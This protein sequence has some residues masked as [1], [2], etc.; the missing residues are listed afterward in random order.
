MLTAGHAVVSSVAEQG[1]VISS[2][3]TGEAIGSLFC[4]TNIDGNPTADA[5][6]IWVDPAKVAARI[7]G[8]TAPTLVNTRPAE[9]DVVRIMPAQVGGVPRQA[10]I[11]AI[12]QAVDL[13]V[14]GPGWPEAPTIT[15]QGQ[16]FTDDLI[17]DAGDSG[18][19]VLDWQ[20]QAVG[21]VVAGSLETGT[22]ITPITAIFA[23][24]A[25]G[26]MRMALLKDI[27][28]APLLP[29]LAPSDSMVGGAADGVADR[30][31]TIAAVNGMAMA[32]ALGAQAQDAKNALTDVVFEPASPEE[33][34][35]LLT[36]SAIATMRNFGVPAS[37]TIA[38][39]ALESGWGKSKL[40][41]NGRNLF[42]VKADVSWTGDKITMYTREFANGAPV[43]VEAV[44]RKYPGLQACLDDHAKFFRDNPRYSGCFQFKDG[45]GFTNAVAGAGY[46]TD[47]NYAKKL[48]AT[49]RAR[50]LGQLDKAF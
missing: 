3:A 13:M 45:E 16:I 27:P 36:P 28:S 31:G 2:V 24:P 21:M 15:Y 26:G 8:L 38:Q 37:F 10:K 18:A 9:G 1:N 48:I 4:W 19:L 25:W 41:T 44:W 22:V 34:I 50:N 47:P 14:G 6:L 43:M 7:R 35:R 17:S 5:A 40:A 20:G 11:R 33:F 23:N 30:E 32:G 12:D 39:G 29:V 49:I 46:A 42:G